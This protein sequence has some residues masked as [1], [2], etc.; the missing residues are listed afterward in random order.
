MEP[1]D[2]MMRAAGVAAGC[3]DGVRVA[4]KQLA[5]TLDVNT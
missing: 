2:E 1:K 3:V 4:T 5:T